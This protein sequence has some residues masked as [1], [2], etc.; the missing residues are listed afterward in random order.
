MI[1]I[2]RHTQSGEGPFH[3]T[4]RIKPAARI[5]LTD[6]RG[7]LLDEFGDDF[8]KYSRSFYISNHTTAGYL[9]QRLAELLEHDGRGIQGYLQLFRELFP[10][11]AGYVHDKLHLRTE[12]SE[13]Q[14]ASEPL[15]ADSHLTF[16]GAGL[17]NSASYKLGGSE[18]VWF[19]ELDGVHLG[20]TRHRR[21]SVIAY[22]HEEEVARKVIPVQSSP[23]AIDALNLRD[24][25]LGFLGTLEQMVARH[26]VAFGRFDVSL[27]EDEQDAGLT[28]NEYEPLLMNYD[29]REALR[30]PFR[31]MAQTGKDVRDVLRDPRTIPAKAINFAQ[32]DAVQVMNQVLDRIGL[33]DSVVERVVNK[34]VAFP[35]S[36]FL[37]MKRAFSLPVL[38]RSGDGTG[39]SVGEIGW[40][41]YQSPILVQ[42]KGAAERTRALEV[43]LVRFV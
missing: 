38:D 33:R 36:H 2:D 10:P 21:T 40:G 16:I 35:V 5:Q 27:P 7:K 4:L 6:V 13:E 9:D 34:A 37:R 42:W 39:D 17:R 30:N 24:P 25:A 12:L 20:G 32:F 19:V 26:K 22:D 18:P 8:T 3:A 1:L 15:N 43:R 11:G 29:L 28:V 23:H 41:T 31:F 14:R